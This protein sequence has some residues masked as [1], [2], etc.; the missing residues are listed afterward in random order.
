[1]TYDEFSEKLM[2]IKAIH[3]QK[4]GREMETLKELEEHLDRMLARPKKSGAR[5]L[6]GLFFK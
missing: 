2:K 4:H 5:S 1:M 6:K 3:K